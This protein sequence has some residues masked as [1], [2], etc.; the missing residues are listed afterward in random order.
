MRLRPVVRAL[1]NRNVLFIGAVL[2]GIAVGDWAVHT[3]AWTLPALALAM[4]LS[5]TQVENSAFWPL[6][7]LVRPALVSVLLSF[8]LEGAAILV[9]ARLLVPDP[10][11][12]PGFVMAAATPPAAGIVA[13]TDIAGGDVT[14]SLL[15]MVG[16]Y[17]GSMVITPAMV[18]LLAGETA[19]EPLALARLLL[20]LVLIPLIASRAILASPLK[21]PIARWRSS[22]ANWAFALVLFTITGLNREVF[23]GEPRLVL[24]I[25]L[26]NVMR[27]FGLAIAI[28]RVMAWRQAG[29][30]RQI[31]YVLMAT[32]KNS[33]F[34]AATALALF[35]ERTAIPS[36]VAGAVAVV[37]LLWLG[38]RWGKAAEASEAQA[39]SKA[40]AER[41]R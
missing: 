19:V 1:G 17:L 28:E 21:G 35:G 20:Q 24:L 27:T 33:G 10:E 18:L 39:A 16:A 40:A 9:S 36:G 29:R 15:G 26:V 11:L 23:F 6:R 12:W 30:P 7:R 25:A 13:F 14:F 31:S 2:L 34:A 32:L 3:K 41:A 5:S 38:I 4:A 22:I 37:Y 8:V